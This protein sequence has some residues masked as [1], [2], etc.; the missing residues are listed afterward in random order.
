MRAHYGV[1]I[2]GAPIRKGFDLGFYDSLVE[3]NDFS[4]LVISEPN[5]YSARNG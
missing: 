2:S 1:Q 4:D 5:S 3:G